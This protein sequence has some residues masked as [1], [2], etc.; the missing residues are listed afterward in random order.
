MAVKQ[1][2]SNVELVEKL[3]EAFN[4]QNTQGVLR[5]M[6]DDVEWTEPEGSPFAGTYHGPDAVLVNVFRPVRKAYD[7]FVVEAER[8]VDAGDTVVCT[9]TFHATT[10]D[11]RKIESPFAHIWE[12]AD[13]EITEMRNYTDTALWA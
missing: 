9:G 12:V 1:Q 6:A 11:G 13:G 3:Y 5:R 4:A 10:K 2:S 8:F 7:P